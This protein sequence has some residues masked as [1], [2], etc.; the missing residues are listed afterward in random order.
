M[1]DSLFINDTKSSTVRVRETK[2]P[3]GYMPIT[4]SS[5]GKLGVPRKIHVRNYNGQ[6]ALDLAMVTEEDV[7]DTLVNILSGMIYEDIDTDQ[8]HEEDFQEIMLNIFFNFWSSSIEYPYEPLEEEL[9]AIDP[10]QAKRITDGEEHL[11]IALSAN[12]IKTKSLTDFEEPIKVSVN[13]IDYTFILPRIGHA[14]NAKFMVEEKFADLE[15]EF[16]II[17]QQLETNQKLKENNR[18]IQLPVSVKDRRRFDKYTKDRAKY[19]TLLTQAQLIK[20]VDG[21]ELLSVEEKEEAYTIIDLQVW[22]EVNLAM[23]KAH[24]GIEKDITVKS[25]LTHEEVI[26]RFQFRWWDFLPSMDT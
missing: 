1:S 3:S 22:R 9:K 26:R 4:L 13:D 18:P 6:D 21:K 25:P 20:S 8:L 23:E 14:I 7:F 11:T 24:F 15:E 12:D 5:N 17:E 10:V 19:F 16:N 2:V